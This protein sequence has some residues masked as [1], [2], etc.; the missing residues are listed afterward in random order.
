[1]LRYV[2]LS[3]FMAM[4]VCA[5]CACTESSTQWEH[6]RESEEKQRDADRDGPSLEDRV[7]ARED[8]AYSL[9]GRVKALEDRVDEL[10]TK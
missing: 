3:L 1:M 5:L 2:I 4:L 8:R 6:L 10:E 7:R 9:E